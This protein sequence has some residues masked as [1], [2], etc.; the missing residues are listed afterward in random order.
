M[1]GFFILSKDFSIFLTHLS[2]TMSSSFVHAPRSSGGYDVALWLKNNWDTASFSGD[3]LIAI[4]DGSRHPIKDCAVVFRNFRTVTGTPGAYFAE[5]VGVVQYRSAMLTAINGAPKYEHPIV[6][7]N[8]V[9]VPLGVPKWDNAQTRIVLQQSARQ[10]VSGGE[11]TA[12]MSDEHV[13]TLYYAALQQLVFYS[14]NA[15][16]TEDQRRWF[17]ALVALTRAFSAVH[18]A[19]DVARKV[20]TALVLTPGANDMMQKGLA[21]I[22]HTGS[23]WTA[24]TRLDMLTIAL[25]RSLKHSGGSLYG[26]AP[27]PFVLFALVPLLRTLAHPDGSVLCESAALREKFNTVT[28]RLLDAFVY[29]DDN[30]YTSTGDK[31]SMK[32]LN[33]RFLVTLTDVMDVPLYGWQACA[34]LDY[35]VGASSHAPN[36]VDMKVLPP[37]PVFV[38]EVSGVTCGSATHVKLDPKDTNTLNVY[39]YKGV[40]W[41]A[42]TLKTP[43]SYTVMAHD[44]GIATRSTGDTRGCELNANWR[45][46]VGNDM[47]P[48]TRSGYS[49]AGQRH[50]CTTRG[51]WQYRPSVPL[52]LKTTFDITVKPTEVR[53]M[54]DGRVFF[55]MEKAVHEPALLAF[56]NLW[57]TVTYAPPPPPPAFT[58]TPVASLPSLCPAPGAPARAGAGAP[59]HE[60][61]VLDLPPMALIARLRELVASES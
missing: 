32:E 4:H 42:I 20:T 16:R 38:A 37:K 14:G 11:N 13:I 58:V 40:E 48:R 30:A 43:G 49:L 12:D 2:Y 8:D 59:S 10:W 47:F 21:H 5:P 15:T 52:S 39:S 18:G 24:E 45:L 61:R 33:V 22:F 54:Q 6:V 55:A 44:L 7:K 50:I 19:Y 29:D 3:D 25:R 53:L 9:L 1:A 28:Q 60:E 41:A 31:R 26:M 23:V 57:L 51:A 34:L 56:K 46:T 17:P 36:W 27:G 35:V